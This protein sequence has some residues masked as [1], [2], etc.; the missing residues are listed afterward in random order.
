MSELIR[1]TLGFL[2]VATIFVIVLRKPLR[3]LR[4]KPNAEAILAEQIA[5]AQTL[6][7][8]L[9]GDIARLRSVRSQALVS[10]AWDS[11]RRYLNKPL[12]QLSLRDVTVVALEL[13]HALVTLESHAVIQN[14]PFYPGQNQEMDALVVWMRNFASW[15]QQ[16]LLNGYPSQNLEDYTAPTSMS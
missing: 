1:A 5:H 10:V 6:L 12:D 2:L 8:T 11:L 9:Q 15:S 7:A 16:T 3:R 13:Q 14:S 4:H